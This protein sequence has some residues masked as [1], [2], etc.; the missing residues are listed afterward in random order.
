MTSRNGSRRDA[1][2]AGHSV[3]EFSSAAKP[4]QQAAQP[5][6]GARSRTELAAT[7]PP[8]AEVARQAG[9]DDRTLPLQAIRRKCLDCS[10]YQPSEVRQCEAVNCPLWP[11]RAGKYPAGR[12]KPKNPDTDRDSEQGDPFHGRPRVAP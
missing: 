5:Q 8:T 12:H 7:W 6:A 9:H 3:G 4:S 2:A 1:V 11:F 10:C